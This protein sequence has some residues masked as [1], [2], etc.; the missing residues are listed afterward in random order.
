[1][2]LD[3]ASPIIVCDAIRA[4]R[5]EHGETPSAIQAR[6]YLNR[7]LCIKARLDL[8]VIVTLKHLRHMLPNPLSLGVAR[9]P[10]TNEADEASTPSHP[11]IRYRFSPAPQAPG[12][13]VEQPHKDLLSDLVRDSAAQSALNI[14]GDAQL[15]P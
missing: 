6:S 11:R 15:S 14:L 2:R 1:M 7:S 10:L 8:S 12:I 5:Q 9:S 3:Q 13:S 4:H